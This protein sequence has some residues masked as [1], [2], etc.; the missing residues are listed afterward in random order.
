MDDCAYSS[1]EGEPCLCQAFIVSLDPA[2]IIEFMEKRSKLQYVACDFC[3]VVIARRGNDF[4]CERG[5]MVN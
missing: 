4:I 2:R 5:E 3:G 1:A